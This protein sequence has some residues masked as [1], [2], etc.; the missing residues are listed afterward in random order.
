MTIKEWITVVATVIVMSV[1]G[2]DRTIAEEPI[3]VGAARQLFVD[4]LFFATSSGVSLK[5]QPPQKKG[6]T[7]LKSEHPWE[8]ATVNW[9]SVRQSRWSG[10]SIRK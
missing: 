10:G 9:F 5:I 7:I 3:N 6:E 2:S 1:V 4:E 8:S